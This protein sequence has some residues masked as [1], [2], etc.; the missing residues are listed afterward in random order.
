MS[1]CFLG[2]WAVRSGMFMGCAR[3]AG[4]FISRDVGYSFGHLFMGCALLT[5][6]V[7]SWD[8]GYWLGHLFMGCALLAGAFFS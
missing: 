3:L 8:V 4:A 2:L 5:G 7:F 6:A 1:H